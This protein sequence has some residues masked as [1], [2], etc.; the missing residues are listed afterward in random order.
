MKKIT[1]EK[2][3]VCIFLAQ[4]GLKVLGGSTYYVAPWGDNSNDG[5]FENPWQTIPYAASHSGAG[6]TVYVRGGTYDYPDGIWIRGIYGQG[7]D[8]TGYWVLIN[9]PGEEPILIMGS[10]MRVEAPYVIIE[11]LHFVNKGVGLYMSP[12]PDPYAAHHCIVRNNLFTGTGFRYGAIHVMGEDCIVENNVIRDIV[13]SSSLDHGIYVHTSRRNIVRNNYISGAAGWGIHIYDEKKSYSEPDS[14]RIIDDLVV[15]SNFIID[16]GSGGIIVATGLNGFPLAKNIII[17]NNIIVQNQGNPGAR[18]VA[19]RSRAENIKIYNNTIVMYGGDKVGV[20]IAGC[21]GSADSFKTIY[22]TY[23]KNNIIYT[24]DSSY[25]I[26][27]GNSAYVY[28]LRVNTNL[29]SNLNNFEVTD[30]NPVISDPLFVNPDSTDFHLQSISP[31]IDTGLMLSEVTHDFDG[32]PRPYDGDNDGIEKMDIGA[33]EYVGPTL[34]KES[35][36]RFFTILKTGTIFFDSKVKISY[37]LPTKG[38]VVLDI[39]SISGKK[40]TTLINKIQSPGQKFLIWDGKDKEGN[41]L[42]SG[43]YFYRLQFNRNVKGAKLIILK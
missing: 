9:Y 30:S 6:D 43:L 25:S 34:I 21:C 29:Y 15:E 42:P 3:L 38:K 23:V 31:A 28:N 11:G 4:V 26:Y 24:E 18:G 13:Q 40:I 27:L 5:S 7:G 33:Y 41:P 8:S 1:G 22:D 32:N 2:V 19:V 35:N 12:I 16:N 37:Y 36:N 20:R 17:K 10:W 14:I 39:Y